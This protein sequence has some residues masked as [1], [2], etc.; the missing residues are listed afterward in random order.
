MLSWLME[1]HTQKNVME[2]AA[3]LFIY[4]FCISDA[5]VLT[6]TERDWLLGAENACM[7]AG[8]WVT[9]FPHGWEA[10]G[11]S[12]RKCLKEEL[13]RRDAFRKEVPC[14]IQRTD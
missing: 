6:E 3:C 8:R 2:L 13:D 10:A 9:Q 1:Q 5:G 11:D 12:I 14:D 4:A 7:E